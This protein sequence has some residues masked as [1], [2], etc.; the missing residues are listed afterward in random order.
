MSNKDEASEKN[1]NIHLYELNG[2]IVTTAELAIKIAELFCEARFGK[3]DLER[4]RPFVAT[5][6]GS[7]WR[8]EGS[9]NRDGKIEGGAEFYASIEKRDGRI[10]DLG[11]YYRLPP[12]DLKDLMREL[13]ELPEPEPP[14]GFSE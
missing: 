14:P 9:W 3:E 1:S 8:V 2:G 4:Q 12:R 10:R 5:D 11:S 6:K 7:Y 13:S